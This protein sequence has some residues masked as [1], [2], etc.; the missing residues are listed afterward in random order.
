[1][2]GQSGKP[3]G[4][5][6]VFQSLNPSAELGNGVLKLGELA[7][8]GGCGRVGPRFPL[9]G[10]FLREV[11]EPRNGFRVTVLGQLVQ[12]LLRCHRRDLV[13]FREGADGRQPGSRGEVAAIDLPRDLGGHLLVRVRGD[14]VLIHKLTVPRRHM[15]R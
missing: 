14:S 11:A 7:V 1:M 8:N 12:R 15:T 9:G 13:L 10:G 6:T 2:T 3:Q 4:L 5:G